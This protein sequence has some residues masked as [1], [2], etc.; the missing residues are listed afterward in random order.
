MKVKQ[1]KMGKRNK[2][3]RWLIGN[4]N[5]KLIAASFDLFVNMHRE[6]IPLVVRVRRNLSEHNYQFRFKN[7]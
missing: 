6:A 7:R 5:D 1:F 3:G 2:A 4:L